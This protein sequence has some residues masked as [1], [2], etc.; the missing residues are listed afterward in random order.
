MIILQ[1][2]LMIS[3]LNW[4]LHIGYICTT[5]YTN[6]VS[7]ITLLKLMCNPIKQD[8]C[9]IHQSKPISVSLHNTDEIIMQIFSITSRAA[10]ILYSSATGL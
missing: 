2:V 10:S 8:Q 9:V 3:L 4:S 7:H 5:I 1:E 6:L